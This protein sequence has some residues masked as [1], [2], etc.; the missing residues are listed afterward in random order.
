MKNKQKGIVT[1]GFTPSN[2]E[3][4]LKIVKDC[5][6]STYGVYI[7]ILSH[8]NTSTNECF[9]KNDIIAEECSCS[10]ANIKKHIN[11]LYDFG[12]LVISSGYTGKASN[13][14]FPSEIDLNTKKS[15]YTD[16]ELDRISNIIRR[17]KDNTVEEV[18]AQDIKIINDKTFTP[19]GKYV[20]KIIDDVD[21]FEDDLP[22]KDNII[23]LNNDSTGFIN[24]FYINMHSY[25]NVQDE[26][27]KTNK[28]IIKKV[29]ELVGLIDAK[30]KE[31]DFNIPAGKVIE[32]ILNE[33]QRQY[34]KALS[35]NSIDKDFN[36]CCFVIGCLQKA[37]DEEIQQYIRNSKVDKFPP[38][39]EGLIDY[40]NK[41]DLS[42]ENYKGDD[43]FNYKPKNKIISINKDKE[44]V[45]DGVTYAVD[46]N[47]FSYVVN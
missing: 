46:K 10:V 27:L 14:Y 2:N 32:N 40:M 28:T 5:G 47:G 24:E 37:L 4:R 18:P 38:A 45:E 36:I 43:L 26:S 13:Y 42:N 20:D 3:L 8:R 1:T 30:F 25:F 16:A 6:L 35:K 21:L 33:K 39:D 41:I 12:Y 34:K 15:I 9:P 31:Q 11:K 19:T 22:A 23:K 44:Y 17:T 7:Q 29:N